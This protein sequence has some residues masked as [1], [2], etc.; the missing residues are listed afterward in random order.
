MVRPPPPLLCGLRIHLT[1]YETNLS[2]HHLLLLMNTIFTQSNGSLWLDQWWEVL[3]TSKT[4][5]QNQANSPWL[6]AI[7]VRVDRGTL[8]NAKA[9]THINRPLVSFSLLWHFASLNSTSGAYNDCLL[10]SAHSW[11]YT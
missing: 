4:Q 5:K 8:P 9:H 10:Q 11:I 2:I 7:S 6:K 3:L 1:D